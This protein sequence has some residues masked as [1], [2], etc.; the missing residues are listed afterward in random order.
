MDKKIISLALIHLLFP[1]LLW[2]QPNVLEWAHS[3][4]QFGFEYGNS[5]AVDPSG[6]VLVT[7]NFS[8]TTDFDPS[9]GVYNLTALGGDDIF[10]AKYDED[11]SLYW[12]NAIACSSFAKAYDID[13]DAAGNVYLTGYFSIAADFD[14]LPGNPL[15][16]ASGQFDSFFAKYDTAGALVWVKVISSNSSVYSRRIRVDQNHHVIITGEFRDTT[17]F[18]PDTSTFP[19]VSAGNSDLFLAKYDSSGNYLWVRRAGGTA[20]ETAT[21]LDVDQAGNIYYTGYFFG[22]FDFDPGP[23][24][25]LLSTF[26]ASDV[27]FARYTSA[28]GLDFVKQIG[29][30]GFDQCQDLE[31]DL[32]GRILITGLCAPFMDFDPGPGV[33]NRDSVGFLDIFTAK[34]STQGNFIFANTF[35][36]T[37]I[38]E[39][40]SITADGDEHI[41]VT[42]VVADTTDFDPGPGTDIIYGAGMDDAFVTSFDAT[43]AYR[44]AFTLAGAATEKGSAIE[45]TTSGTL[46]VTGGFS[47]TVDFDPDTN[48][49]ALT[50][51]ANVDAFLARYSRCSTDSV[52]VQLVTCDSTFYNGQY[53]Q[54]P[55]IY[56]LSYTPILGC[57]STIVLEL[58]PPLIDTSLTVNSVTITSAA[59]GVSY[60]WIDCGNGNVP[61]PGDTLQSFTATVNG[62][63]AVV[64]SVNGC[65]DTSSCVVINGV[66]L[67]A[68]IAFGSLSVYPN[69]VRSEFIISFDGYYGSQTLIDLYDVCGNLVQHVF[70]GEIQGGTYHVHSELSKLSAGIYVL[71]MKNQAVT[72]AIRIVKL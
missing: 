54:S 10:L 28:G 40:L 32:S 44:W 2:A 17:D 16:T 35:G 37:G 38:D 48:V 61:L 26:G 25:V 22:T 52:F 72:L 42:G 45:A 64:L 23:A 43:G 18:D 34:Y 41:Y 15:L 50:S 39:A 8:G 67:D 30:P 70:E 60:Q 14:P 5:L 55:G 19:I 36:S 47:D 24:V 65:S 49:Y 13:T 68:G 29:S 69:P 12:A 71:K 51:S 27:F 4:G 66:G 11:G 56:V 31:L 46:Y 20:L 62:T 57:D 58:A 33:I 7:G 59:T 9:T 21:G 3:I 53:F 6:N 1:C 63:Y